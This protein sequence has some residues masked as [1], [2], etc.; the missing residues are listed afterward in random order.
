MIKI[1]ALNKVYHSKKRQK[2]FALNDVNLVLPDNGLVF[3]LGKSGSGKS[4]LLNL[5]GGLDSITS[6]SIEVDGND[7]ASFKEKDFCNYRNSHIG[8][9]FQDYHL[10]DEL[11]VYENIAF[12]LN[13]L[14]QEV[15]DK[16]K[17]ALEKVDLAGY[18]DRYP[19]E[20]SGGEQQRVAIA[21]ALVKSPKIILADEP[22]GNLDT[23]TSTAIIKLLKQ[24]SKECLILIVSHNV[25]DANNYANRI[26]ELKGGRVLSDVTKNPD[27][28]DSVTLQDGRLVYPKDSFLSDEDIRLIN[29]N[30]NESVKLIKRTD[31]FIQTP[32]DDPIANKVQI[33]NKNLSLSKQVKL[34]SKFLHNKTLTIV[35]SSFIVAVI[36]VIMAF[37]QTITSFNASR[38]IVSEMAKHDLDSMLLNKT[39]P[40]EQQ[41]IYYQAPLVGVGDLDQQAFYDAGYRGKIYPVLNYTI[42]NRT[43]TAVYGNSTTRFLGPYMTVPMGTMVVDQDFLTRKFGTISY[44]A[45]AEHQMPYGLI[46][47]DYLADAVLLCNSKY[48]NK[49]YQDVVGEF[50]S[51]CYTDTRAYVNAI[52]DTGYK[53]KYG[54]FL[55]QFVNKP[56]V[57]VNELYQYEEFQPFL[58]DIYDHLGFTYTTNPNFKQSLK[59]SPQ[60]QYIAHYKVVFNDLFELNTTSEPYSINS[61]VDYDFPNEK[62]N[63]SNYWRYT[64]EI[65]QIPQNAKYIRVAFHPNIDNSYKIY[66]EVTTRTHALL[67]FSNQ[68]EIPASIMNTHTRDASWSTSDG[69]ALSVYDGSI[70]KGKGGSSPKISDYIEIPEGATIEQFGAIAYMGYPYCCFYD[71][72]KNFISAVTSALGEELPERTIRLSLSKFNQTFGT[73]YSQEEAEAIVPRTVKMTHYNTYDEDKSHP[74][75][76]VN[77][78]IELLSDKMQRTFSLSQDLFDLFYEDAVR[79]ISYY[80]YGMDGIDGAI[81]LMDIL[82]YQPQSY[83]VEGIRTMTRAVEVFIPIFQLVSIILYVAVIFILV[84]FSSKMI[85]D[86]MHEIGIMKALGAK[87]RTIFII[88]GMQI[89]LIAIL[90]CVMATLGHFL[91]IGVANDV[92]IE[93]LKRLASGWTVMDLEFLTFKPIL[94]LNNCILTVLLSALSL[95]VPMIKIKSIK[96]V[97]IIKAKE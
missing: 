80:F 84:N 57:S 41:S 3:V 72:D 78:T 39:L 30:C 73:N 66:N 20:L 63:L 61:I 29:E 51:A 75:F 4:T 93:S 42:I 97:K 11:T 60:G 28:N 69:V 82:N 67:K 90:T 25:N 59:T 81:E 50:H 45:Q 49:T 46:L 86:K 89:G 68:E 2:C 33:A 77:V 43:G 52:I 92:L 15:G 62:E 44:L 54:E 55:S 23:A 18:E 24:L 53:A 87:N 79:P 8:F 35:L 48:K 10:L 9:I 13:M 37:A 5:L 38:V 17:L 74:L 96:P 70:I 19:S 12:S 83:A 95:V 6:G 64:T 91:F 16:I 94:A 34:S 71:E 47:T 85:N 1:T 7:L 22:T 32:S 27:F 31:K 36:M 76:E 26:I 40:P 65:P 88:F 58:N 14:N 21:R 56:N